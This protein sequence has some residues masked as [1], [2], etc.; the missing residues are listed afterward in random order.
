MLNLVM[1]TDERDVS[2]VLAD[3]P[4][5]VH[6]P[7]V[8]VGPAMRPNNVKVNPAVGIAPSDIVEV[9]P[10]TLEDPLRKL[11]YAADDWVVSAPPTRIDEETITCPTDTPR[12]TEIDLWFATISFFIR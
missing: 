10:T 8:C 6:F 7:T 5:Q 1:N 11:I 4:I 2:P 3:S 9:G 12:P